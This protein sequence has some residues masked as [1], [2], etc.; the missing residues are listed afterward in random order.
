MCALRLC[1]KLQASVS[2]LPL[3]MM[4]TCKNPKYQTQI[5]LNKSW[6]LRTY[7]VLGKHLLST[8]CVPDPGAG[9][10]VVTGMVWLL[11]DSGGTC[12]WK[13]SDSRYDEASRDACDEEKETR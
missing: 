6:V 10:T 2:L 1:G 7:S 4:I 9:N 8:G 3:Q 12:C 11:V 13:C 5:F